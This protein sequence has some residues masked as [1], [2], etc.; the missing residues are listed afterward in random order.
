MRRRLEE[1]INQ[2][3]DNFLSIE[4]SQHP[5]IVSARRR[6]ETEMYSFVSQHQGPISPKELLEHVDTQIRSWNLDLGFLT[7][8]AHGAFWN[9]VDQGKLDFTPDRRVF[10]IPEEKAKPLEG[11]VQNS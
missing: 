7:T 1:G 4:Y 2:T 10:A 9:L 11:C 8:M 3:V 6:A 5:E